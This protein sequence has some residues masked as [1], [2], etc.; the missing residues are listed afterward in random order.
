MEFIKP[1]LFRFVIILIILN[2]TINT[3]QPK[4]Q[5]Y[6]ENNVGWRTTYYSNKDNLDSLDMLTKQHHKIK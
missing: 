4:P 2:K 5:K 6:N 3:A 1:I